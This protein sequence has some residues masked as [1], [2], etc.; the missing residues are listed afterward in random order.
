MADRRRASEK[1][2]GAQRR[3]G[4]SCSRGAQ[5]ATA[6]S[7]VKSKAN[8]AGE[9]E[10]M[11]QEAL[12]R[13]LRGSEEGLRRTFTMLRRCF[14]AFKA[15]PAACLAPRQA[16]QPASVPA[17]A[18]RAITK[19]GGASVYALLRGQFAELG[20]GEVTQRE[21]LC[22]VRRRCGQVPALAEKL[23][24]ETAKRSGAR[25]FVVMA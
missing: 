12:Q 21:L 24:E 25:K 11:C 2:E 13:L 3:S 22:F 16:F 10:N 19:R 1:C 14:K 4:A 8:E 5:P 6:A 15:F 20:G 9:H 17:L 18:Q 23:L 7:P